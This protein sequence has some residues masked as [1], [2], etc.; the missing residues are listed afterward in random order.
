NVW[1]AKY[2]LTLTAS[3]VGCFQYF[4]SEDNNTWRSVYGYGQYMPGETLRS[5]YTSGKVTENRYINLVFGQDL[6]PEPRRPAIPSLSE[7]S[8]CQLC[9]HKSRLKHQ[10][11]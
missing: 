3:L 9:K 2:L 11:E 6:H 10:K 8:I 1:N 4:D 5:G 7:Q